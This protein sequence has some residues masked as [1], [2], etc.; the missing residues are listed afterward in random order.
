MAS[1]FSFASIPTYPAESRPVII[2][3]GGTSGIGKVT[4]RELFKH[5]AKVYLLARS[6][7]KVEEVLSELKDENPNNENLPIWIPCDMMDLKSVVEAATKFQE[8]ETKLDVLI[9]NAGIMYIPYEETSDGYESTIQVNYFAPYLLTRMLIPTLSN[10]L[11]PR[12]VNISSIAYTFT[13][14]FN[15]EDPNLK[16]GWELSLKGFRYAQSKLAIISFTKQ[17]AIRY[18]NI[19][20]IAVHPGVITDT[21]LYDG[22][23]NS[24]ELF[25][26]VRMSGIILQAVAPK[27]G[28]I[29]TEDGA[30]TSL[31]CATAPELTIGLDNGGWYV[32]IAEKSECSGKVCDGEFGEELWN[33]TE[34]QLSS[35]GYL[36]AE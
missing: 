35:K 18:P 24:K 1:P 26:L 3:T 20:S 22:L 11:A 9:N 13:N 16:K 34:E 12:V 2:V 4:V 21:A 14:K 30:L 23:L 31:Y 25:G 19:L 33:W 28:G 7:Q 8:L 10:S 5:G 29:S 15:F 17:M 32:P 36:T 27:L 6:G